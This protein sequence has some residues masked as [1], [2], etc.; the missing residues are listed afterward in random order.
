[1]VMVAV[2]EAYGGACDA[3]LEVGYHVPARHEAV[4]SAA[5]LMAPVLAKTPQDSASQH[6]LTTQRKSEE[7]DLGCFL[8]RA[9]A[10]DLGHRCTKLD[11]D[12]RVLQ[13]PQVAH[14]PRAGQVGGSA[15]E[16]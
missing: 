8:R 16:P 11:L 2:G 6:K 13:A 9:H 5:D 10:L 3:H 4:H 15:G 1:M 12:V 7:G 14:S